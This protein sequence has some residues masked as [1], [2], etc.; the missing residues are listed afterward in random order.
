M[1]PR[2]HYNVKSL[3][4]NSFSMERILL[5]GDYSNLRELKIFSFNVKIASRY[6]TVESTFRLFLPHRIADLIL[7]DVDVRLVLSIH[8]QPHK[9]MKY[10]T[11]KTASYTVAITNPSVN[12]P[13]KEYM[14]CT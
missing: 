3:T 11:L 2:I 8:P 14:S 1:L 6:F 7:E 12:V 5:A 9:I 10:K 13:Y 4:L